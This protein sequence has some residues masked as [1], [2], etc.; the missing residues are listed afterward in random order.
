MDVIQYPNPLHLITEIPPDSDPAVATPVIGPKTAIIIVTKDRVERLRTTLPKI[1][2]MPCPVILID[3]STTS[4]SRR[5]VAAIASRWDIQYH[6][7]T[8]QKS[9]LA[10][11]RIKDLGGLVA[12]LGTPGWTL[13]FCRNYTLLLARAMGFDRV[14]LMDDDIV[15]PSQDLLARTLSLLTDFHYAGAHTIGLPDDS[16]VGHV[17]RRLGVVQYDFV[18]GQYL[19]VRCR[20]QPSFFPNEYNE[21]LLFLLLGAGDGTIARYG[22]VRQLQHGPSGLSI[23][24]ALSEEEG[25]VHC[26]GCIRVAISGNR[27]AL[28]D[29][30]FWVDV[31]EF[32]WK[33][34]LDLIAR[35]QEW[36]NSIYTPL[37]TSVLDRSRR[38]DPRTFVTFY[39]SYFSAIPRWVALQEQFG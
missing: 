17:A 22:T 28:R 16:V 23:G 35:D 15:L 32:R 33:S 10:S 34:L 11:A 5:R 4:A 14:V 29:S 6:G 20:L 25:E 21:D 12:P 13:G 18:T 3:D 1:A 7:R 39:D 37:L 38:L 2:V 31:L 24:R 9:T 26:E 30:K 27:M 19:G 8:Q 36:G